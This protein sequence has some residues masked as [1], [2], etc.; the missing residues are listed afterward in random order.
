MQGEFQSYTRKKIFGGQTLE[1]VPHEVCAIST[2][3]EVLSYVH[4]TRPALGGDWTLPSNDS[5]WFR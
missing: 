1:Q 2:L 5:P 4:K 3:D